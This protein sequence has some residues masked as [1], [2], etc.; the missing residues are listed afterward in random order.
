MFWRFKENFWR[1]LLSLP[2]FPVR[3]SADIHFSFGSWDTLGR[4]EWITE[5]VAIS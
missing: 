5:I 2:S 4:Q 1:F 3:Q